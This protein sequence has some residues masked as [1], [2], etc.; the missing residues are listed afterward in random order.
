MGGPVRPPSPR[1]RRASMG[2]ATGG[3]PAL[4]LLALFILLAAVAGSSAGCGHSPAESGGSGGGGNRGGS[5]ADNGRDGVAPV[6]GS[7]ASATGE[8]TGRL[9]RGRVL[10]PAGKTFEVEVVQDARSREQGLKY[11]TEMAENEGMLF[12]FPAVARQRFWM[13]ECRIPLDI[14][15]LDADRRVVYVGEKLPICSSLPCP[16]YGP[17]LDSLYVLELGAGVSARSGIHPGVRLEIL[18]AEPSNPS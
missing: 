9:L 13:Y 15:W 10:A 18:F 8:R 1:D 16:D 4:V 11:R 6:A 7:G 3:A 14:I 5:P 17:D 12:L 2:R